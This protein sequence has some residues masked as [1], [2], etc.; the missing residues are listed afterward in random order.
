VCR[1]LLDAG[2]EAERMRIRAWG[3]SRPLVW[4]HG[5]PAGSANRRVELFISLGD[6]EAPARRRLCAYAVEPGT[7]PRPDEPEKLGGNT[8]FVE[9]GA[10]EVLSAEAIYGDDMD[11]DE[12]LMQLLLPT[13]QRFIVPARMMSQLQRWGVDGA[14][15]ESDDD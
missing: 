2:V 15:A 7:A 5:E 4:A 8:E 6:F 13:G 12:A 3:D 14:H 1:A 9:L 10:D 11:E